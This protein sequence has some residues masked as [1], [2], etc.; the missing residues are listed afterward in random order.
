MGFAKFFL[1]G[2]LLFMPPLAAEQ[3]CE[4]VFRGSGG[5]GAV[6]PTRASAAGL[7]GP[8]ARQGGRLCPLSRDDRNCATPPIV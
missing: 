4:D 8:I 6:K 2:T 5:G 3:R 7:I 1:A